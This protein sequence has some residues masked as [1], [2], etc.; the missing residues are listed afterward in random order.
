VA[1]HGADSP[2]A[3]ALGNDFKGKASVVGYAVAIPVA[4]V[5]PWIACALYVLIAV[6]WLVPDRRIERAL[7]EHA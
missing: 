4:F 2:L 1:C 6:L 7:S 3:S 5:R